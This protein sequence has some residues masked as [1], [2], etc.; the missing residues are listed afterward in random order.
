MASRQCTS[1]WWPRWGSS[2]TAPSSTSS[3]RFGRCDA[4]NQTKSQII[5]P[6]AQFRSMQLWS[7]FNFLIFNLSVNELMAAA[8]GVP[9]DFLASIN[10]GWKMG[11][12]VCNVTGFGHTLAGKTQ[13]TLK[14][15]LFF[16]SIS[17]VLRTLFRS[18]N[19]LSE[20]RDVEIRT[21]LGNPPKMCKNLLMFGSS[22]V[23]SICILDS[24]DRTKRAIW[25]R[26]STHALAF[27]KTS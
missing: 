25:Q 13:W 19:I 8:V 18:P 15:V 27:D 6:H 9:I 24:S 22:V 16:I 10:Y 3:A 4:R 17:S 21:P 12:T 11:P 5:L 23:S 20:A 1:S 2:S 26:P 14:K 7:S